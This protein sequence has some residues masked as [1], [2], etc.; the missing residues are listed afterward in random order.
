MPKS[1]NIC[2]LVTGSAGFI[3]S[4]LLEPLARR[5][6]LVRAGIRR[7]VKS[8]PAAP[9][10]VDC[11]CDLD[12]SKQT[13]AAVTGSDLVVHAAYGS[14]AAMPEQCRTLLAAMSAAGT[15]YLV[16]FSSI[17]V[18][19]SAEG[20]I[21]EN[22]ALPEQAGGYGAAKSQCEDLIHKWVDEQP[23]ARR[24]I[25]LRPGIVY[26]AGSTLWV[27]KMIQR[28]RCGAWGTFGSSGDGLAAL[29][30]VDDVAEL[31]VEACAR[32]A[33]APETLP[34]VSIMNV[35][36]PDTPTWNEYFQ[37]LA[38]A[39]GEA[40]LREI[41]PRTLAFR[42]IAAVFAKVWRK[43]GL[44]GGGRAALAPTSSE[45]KLFS[46]KASYATDN[47]E[48]L[49]GFSATIGLQEGLRRSLSVR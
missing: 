31:I 37:A 49:L 13:K 28:I 33:E 34:T 11:S 6:G 46:L 5:G 30:H 36:G 25:I 9:N 4:S 19:G 35:V 23:G 1:G 38:A 10:I 47:A 42:L 16:Y 20:T 45:L 21:S 15:S 3:G 26:G 17:A 41:P 7:S 8:A 44:P 18:Y 40:T 48:T 12:D 24:A 43:I 29:V 39:D 22:A 2:I 14:H 32:L 27:G